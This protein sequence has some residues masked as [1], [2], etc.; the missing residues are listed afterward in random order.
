MPFSG[1]E[2]IDFILG[3]GNLLLNFAKAIGEQQEQKIKLKLRMTHQFIS[4]LLGINRVT[5]VRILK[6][7]KEMNLIEQSRHYFYITDPEGLKKYQKQ[8]ISIDI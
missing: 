8:L 5:G 7:L 6:K 1:K 3:S 2:K 4:D